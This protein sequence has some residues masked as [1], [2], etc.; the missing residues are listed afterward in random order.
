MNN[1]SNV[2]YY[3]L[4]NVLGFLSIDQLNNDNFDE[5]AIH[6]N[7]ESYFRVGTIVDG[8]GFVAENGKLIIHRDDFEFFEQ[9][10]VLPTE[11]L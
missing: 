4:T 11:E 5:F 3:K 1:A 7:G 2:K 9:V 6:V 10:A 8:S